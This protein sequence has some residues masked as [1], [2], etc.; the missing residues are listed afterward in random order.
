MEN[1][2]ELSFSTSKS[3]PLILQSELAQCG[4]ASMAMI[5]CYHGHKLDM[6]AIRNRFS[7]KMKGMDLQQLI[8]LGDNLGL[9]SRALQ[10]PIDEIH[11][12][13]TPCILH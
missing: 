1:S 2:I 9:A 12:L 4:L 5:A 7:A 13:V 6:P 10:C 11:K 3:V 8:D